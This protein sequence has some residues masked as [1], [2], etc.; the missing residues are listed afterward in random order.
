VKA[1]CPA[2]A[3][4]IVRFH[5]T[6]KNDFKALSNSYKA[7]ITI[8]GVVYPTV[9]H[10][11]Q[12][13]KFLSTAPEYAE[14]IRATSNPALIKNMGKTKKIEMRADWETVQ[15]DVMRKALRAKFSQHSD[16]ATLLRSTGAA[17][18]EEESPSDAFWG[19]GADGAGANH[20]GVLLAEIRSSL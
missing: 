11:F 6:L 12:C 16:L 20:L 8:D 7:D 15:M 2:A 13:A 3:D 1:V 14:K 10:Y 4:G 17:R 19:I 5:A 9:E 18:L